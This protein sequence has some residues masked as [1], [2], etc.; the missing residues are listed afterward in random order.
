M[1][2][3]LFEEKEY[4]IKPAFRRNKKERDS[5]AEL[6][7]LLKRTGAKRAGSAGGGAGRKT[8][9]RQ[10][11]VVKA[12]YSNSIEAH[13]VQLE[14]YLAREGTALD[15]SP[16]SLF[17]TDIEE[18]K[19]NMAGKNFR[20]FLS[21]QSDKA[22][23]KALTEKFV[24]RLET[25]T[26]YQF[27]WQGACHYNTAHPHAHLLING[28]DKH[29]KD[30]EIPRDVIKTFMREAAR[31]ICTSQL[32]S[33]SRADME[34]EREKEAEARRFTR[35]DEQIKTLCGGTF[36]PD[37]QGAGKDR[38]RVLRRLECLAK[39]GLCKY[40]S[41]GY[42]LS[43]RWEE[44]LK[45]NGRYN[46]FLHSRGVLR[47]SPPASLRLYQGSA[48]AVTGKV[49]KIYR[50]DGDASDNHAVVLEGLDGRA[51]FVPLFKKPSVRDGE[52]TAAL[53][54]GDLITLKSFE[55]S[56]GRLTPLMF[57]TDE[58]R[59]RKLAKT[60]GYEGKL[61]AE[62]QSGKAPR[63]RERKQ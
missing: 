21:P 9:A 63:T 3:F 40:E 55:N 60:G 56:K 27:Y 6:A 34:L 33:R 38:A 29:G 5:A 37:A 57:K 20:I 50:T 45:T 61:A 13:R 49:A 10:K 18:Y 53:K 2:H 17:G 48:K 43:P 47:Y 23:L 51:Y 35:L 62:L 15:G 22:D 54:E 42:K 32:G 4:K 25:G 28:T 8:D 46:A 44:N 58:E 39:L 19:E 1:R 7:R 14:K 16:A 59:A 12:Q 36:R 41:G 26:G 52:K 31:D 11:C 24:K 30:V